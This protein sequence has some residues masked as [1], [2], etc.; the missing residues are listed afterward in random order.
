MDQLA[1][2]GVDVVTAL[3]KAHPSEAIGVAE[4]ARFA[5]VPCAISFTVETDGRLPNG[6]DLGDAVNAVDAATASSVA[7]FMINCAHPTHFAER[8]AGA[9]PWTRRI[10]GVRPNASTASHAEL[11]AV[12]R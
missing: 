7:Y 1:S 5:E 6:D 4:A 10:R 3:T 9:E 2:A 11:E 12:A 8:L